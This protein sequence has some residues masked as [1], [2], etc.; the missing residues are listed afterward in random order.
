[1]PEVCGDA[2]RYFDPTSEEDLAAAVLD[3][4]SAPEDLVERGLE[5]AAHFSWDDCAR[6]HDAVYGELVAS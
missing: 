6:D 3:V 2:A 1:L 5:R 4:L